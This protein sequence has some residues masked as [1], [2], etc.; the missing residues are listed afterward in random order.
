MIVG[1]DFG[2][3]NSGMAVYDGRQVQLLP[4]DPANPNPRVV[5]T[6]LYV[7]NDQTVA[8]GRE[9][10]NR[11][12]EQNTGRAVKFQKV[13]VGE[14]EIRG[15]DM[16]FV[17][18][19]YVMTDVLSPGRLFLSVKTGLRDPDYLGTVIGHSYYSL[20]NL[21]AGYLS[22]TRMRAER[23]LGR[24]VRQVVLGRPVRF[25]TDPQ[26]D[27]L[28]QARL[29]DAAFRAGYEKVYF[30]Y[31][32]IAAAYHYAISSGKRQN[33]LVFD[34][35]GGTL[36]ITVMRLGGNG[37]HEVLATGGI[38]VAG[39]VFDQ[40]LVRAKLPKHF[41][42]GSRYGPRHRELPTPKWIYDVFS[43]WQT[44]MELQT[45]ESRQMLRD[46]AQTSRKRSQ[47]EALI[48]L[49]SGNYT[50]P[51]FDLVEQTKR[52]LS[53]KIGA[54]IDF[55]GPGFKVIEM[56]T[57][58]EFE[59]IIRADITAVDQHLDEVV[60]AS[61]LQPGEIDAVVRTGGSSEIPAFK[62]MLE[63]KFGREKVL[64][65]DIFSSVT[66]GLGV[67]AHGIEAGELELEAHTP[68][69]MSSREPA[70]AHKGVSPVNLELLQKRM[71]A[72]EEQA[73]EAPGQPQR[74]LVLLSLDNELVAR[75]LPADAP[76]SED[77]IS[78]DSLKLAENSRPYAGLTASLDEQLLLVTSQYRFLLLTPRQLIDS[79]EMGLSLDNLLHFKKHE[80]ISTIGRWQEIKRKPKLLLV[81][82]QGYARSYNLEMLCESIEGPVPLQFNQPLPGVPMAVYGANGG[83]DLVL[84]LDSGRAVR[85]S[86][87]S[88]PLA[89]MQAINRR[90]EEK[91]VGTVLAAEQDEIAL[92]TAD[93]Y[94]KRLLAGSVELAPKA[95]SRGRV[96][97]ARRPL[98][99]AGRVEQGA[100]V[101]AIT[102]GGV[103][104]VELERLPL[105][106]GESTK[107][108]PLLKLP[109]GE[110][111]LTLLTL[112]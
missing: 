55:S 18:D 11:H 97:V 41:G 20:E 39:D 21:I 107:S 58:N 16:F 9:A 109:A 94:G 73:N 5:R 69:P 96:M 106:D 31:E 27:K 77:G 38:P 110:E 22:L 30:Q 1:M 76:T 43:N 35:G 3:T 92:V 82:S 83:S 90:P 4:L 72:Q 89:G 70:A 95:N 2:T 48:S 49:V 36:D 29:L 33:I 23:L 60:Q 65:A 100:G 12:F 104:P 71:A 74:S 17:Q 6:A 102:T 91:L 34:F 61:G 103:R 80:Q 93:G 75:L 81:T 52:A 66:S 51:M 24:E 84:A 8:I 63:E 56:V 28:A 26:K 101:W 50:L 32:P 25:S 47:I 79:A 68:E 54:T 88:F 57:R 37:R 59:Q 85:V 45:S 108:Y 13:W 87:N 86:L 112:A 62:R 10:V 42:E 40:K 78:F 111:I 44:I 15:A 19:V 7:T 14:I 67:I 98:G 46:I 53:E 105:E 99:A 64:A